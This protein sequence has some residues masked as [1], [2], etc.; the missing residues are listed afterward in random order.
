MYLPQEDDVLPTDSHDAQYNHQEELQSHLED[1]KIMTVIGRG[2]FG[3]VYLVTKLDN[4][5]P[6]AMKS[7]RKD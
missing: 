5:K 4:G 7:I 2:G 3:K 1:Y 6:Y